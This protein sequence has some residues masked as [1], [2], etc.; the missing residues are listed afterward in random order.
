MSH[1]PSLPDRPTLNLDPDMPVDERLAALRSITSTFHGFTTSFQINSNSPATAN[2][3][4][5]RTLLSSR[6]KTRR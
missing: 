2:P 1:S 4:F 6:R 3:N 5:A